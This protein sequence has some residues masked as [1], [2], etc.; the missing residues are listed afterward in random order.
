MIIKD[1]TTEITTMMVIHVER[2]REKITPLLMGFFPSSWELAIRALISVAKGPETAIM[3]SRVRGGKRREGKKEERD[4][5]R[6]GKGWK[7]ER[8]GIGE[9]RGMGRD[10]KWDE[11]ECGRDEKEGEGRGGMERGIGEG[12]KVG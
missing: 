7:V 1:K 5:E 9:E 4:E 6:D 3:S 12:W 8:G 10:G 11:R 2:G